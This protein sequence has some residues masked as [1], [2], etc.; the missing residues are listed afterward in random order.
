MFFFIKHVAFYFR[1]FPHPPPNPA[2]GQILTIRCSL[3]RRRRQQQ[4]RR[5][6]LRLRRLLHKK[7]WLS[8]YL[9]LRRREAVRQE[10]RK[11]DIVKI[12]F[13]CGFSLFV[14]FILGGMNPNLDLGQYKFII[15]FVVLIA[16]HAL[17]FPFLFH[18][19]SSL[20]LV[21]FYLPLF[22]SFLYYLSRLFISLSVSL[23]LHMS[24]S[25]WPKHLVVHHQSSPSK[26]EFVLRE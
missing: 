18:T 10:P 4:R 17:S 13:F 16:Q 1:Y 22:L 26:M 9:P 23:S 21:Y 6:G 2:Y 5:P 7:Q 24:T 19:F 3:M 20:S 14:S 15:V 12:A 11:L 25:F 8:P